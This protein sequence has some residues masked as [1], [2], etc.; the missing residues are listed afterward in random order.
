[1]LQFQP[2]M[3]NDEVCRS[4]TGKHT[5]TQTYI[6]SKNRGSLF[7][8]IFLYYSSSNILKV[9]RRSPDTATFTKKE[10][11]FVFG[12]II[13][14]TQKYTHK[15]YLKYVSIDIVSVNYELSERK[16]HIWKTESKM[17]VSEPKFVHFSTFLNWSSTNKSQRDPKISPV[18]F[19]Q[20]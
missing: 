3:L 2:P 12:G 5:S 15:Q 16:I 19:L 6:L 20:V 7:T 14:S 9:K 10:T 17:S 13:K 1:M 11:G 8:A 18:V 4:S